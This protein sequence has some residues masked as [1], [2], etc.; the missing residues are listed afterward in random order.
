M[1]RPLPQFVA[2]APAL[3]IVTTVVLSACASLPYRETHQ[4]EHITIVFLDAGSLAE[5]YRLHSGRPAARVTMQAHS[6]VIHRV[7]AF[8]D[9]ETKTIYCK[10]WDFENCGHELHH[11]ILGWFH[12]E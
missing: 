8:Y 1:W 12:E 9:H 6:L 2:L 11:A 4:L 10:K 5:A 3:A 7:R